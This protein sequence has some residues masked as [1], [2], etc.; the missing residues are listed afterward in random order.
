MREDKKGTIKHSE[1]KMVI[2][3]EEEIYKQ[4]VWQLRAPTPE[5]DRAWVSK[6]AFTTWK[7]EKICLFPLLGRFSVRVKCNN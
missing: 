6:S 1:R 5:S 4:S 3:P 7:G 2:N